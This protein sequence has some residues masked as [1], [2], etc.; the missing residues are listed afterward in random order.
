MP[1]QKQ[2]RFTQTDRK[3]QIYSD[4]L[5][6]LNPHPV[7]GDIVRFV[8]ENAVVR[9][10]KNLIF[11]NTGE[12]LYQP[13]I[14]SDIRKLLFEPIN[15]VVAETLSS[16]IQSTIENYEPRARVI[17]VRVTP[18]PDENAYRVA[19]VFM[20]INKQDP[21]SFNVTLTRVR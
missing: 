15:T 8:N 20:V 1:I 4:F 5:T 16:L 7:S 2:D 12:R 14:G 18:L 17:D 11:T 21:V 13:K 19:M 10:I 9:S 3:Q 6:D